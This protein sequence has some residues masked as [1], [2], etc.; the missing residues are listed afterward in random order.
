[1]RTVYTSL[2]PDSFDPT[3]WGANVTIIVHYLVSD[4]SSSQNGNPITG[5]PIY[6]YGV[7]WTLPSSQYNVSEPVAGTYWI[8]INT[9]AVSN[10]G[11]WQVNITIDWPASPATYQERNYIANL[12][13]TSRDSSLTPTYI[14]TAD[15][16]AI[17][18]VTLVYYDLSGHGNIANDTFG[19]H[20]NIFVFN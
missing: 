11:I 2:I 10:L 19:A 20:V 7:G 4:A 5:A 3:P 17:F 1:M 13:V 15:Y 14:P 6:V 8:I 9:S 18:N 16:G 12:V